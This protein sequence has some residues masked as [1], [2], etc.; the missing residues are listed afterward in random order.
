MHDVFPWKNEYSH[1]RYLI[2]SHRSYD[3]GLLYQ[4]WSEDLNGDGLDEALI[5]NRHN[6]W[7]FSSPEGEGLGS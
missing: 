4:L 2:T 3:C 7:I 1:P 5:F 6:I